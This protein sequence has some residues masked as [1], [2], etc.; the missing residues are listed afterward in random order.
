MRYLLVVAGLIAII[1]PSPVGATVEA[2]SPE[3]ALRL[4]SLLDLH[5]VA[6]YAAADPQV[7]G[8]YAA[9]LYF[10]GVQMLTV[11]GTYATP[12]LL[13]RLIAEGNYRQVYTDLSTAADRHGQAGLPPSRAHGMTRGSG[14]SSHYRR[15]LDASIVSVFATSPSAPWL[16]VGGWGSRGCPAAPAP[17]ADGRRDVLSSR[18]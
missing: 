13:D 5:N 9:I 11:A 18:A 8:R 3:R 2:T 12:E 6:A 15:V 4:V 17:R 1:R 7:P 10:P 16:R 14:K